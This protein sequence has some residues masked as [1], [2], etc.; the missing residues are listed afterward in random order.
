MISRLLL[1]L[2][3]ACFLD[4]H[5]IIHAVVLSSCSEMRSP[6]L[7]ERERLKIISYRF[8]F[9]LSERDIAK[10]IKCSPSTVHRVLVQHQHHHD[11]PQYHLRGCNKKLS[12]SQ[13]NHVKNI[14]RKNKNITSSEIQRHL[15]HHDNISVSSRTI[16]RY[17][18]E[19]FHPAKEILVHRLTLKH[20]LDRIDYCMTHSNNNF[21][22][23]VFSDEKPFKL[24][25][26][27]STVWIEDDEPIPVREISSLHT[28]VM[29]WGGIWY[30]GRTELGIVKGKIDH[31]KY[32]QVLKRYLLP[33]MP[34]GNDFLFMHDNAPP[35]KPRI[36]EMTLNDFG[37][38]VLYPGPAHSP[39][40]NPIEHVWSWMR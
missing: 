3:S 35:H 39:D 33:S 24:A 38:N 4:V 21:H 37:V 25:H 18:R 15:F 26:T 1:P 40:F 31:Q 23:I 32:I 5:Q 17:R 22:R 19:I 20:H 11:S 2:R 8:D 27:S 36:V 13:L 16:R 14:I 9:H 10:K 29:V 30:N 12:P 7:T 34:A 28:T 6:N